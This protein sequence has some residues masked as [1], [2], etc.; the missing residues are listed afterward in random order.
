[1]MY[2][3][4]HITNL[5]L[6]KIFIYDIIVTQNIQK[7]FILKYDYGFSDTFEICFCNV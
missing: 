5:Y 1:M 6:E 2:F 4:K 7:S 3:S